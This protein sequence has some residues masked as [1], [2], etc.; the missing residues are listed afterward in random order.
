MTPFKR[1]DIRSSFDTAVLLNLLHTTRLSSQEAQQTES[2]P[3]IWSLIG[4]K[5]GDN[6]QMRALAQS[7]GDCHREIPLHYSVWELPVTLSA[8]PSLFGLSAR[9]RSH[10]KPPWPDLLLTAGRRNEAAALWIAKA[11]RGSTKLV[12][13]GRPWHHP[14]RFDLVLTT[15]QYMLAAAEKIFILDLPLNT[16]AFERNVSSRFDHLPRPH[17]ALLIGGHSGALTLHE[18]LARELLGHAS[19]LT[20]T[21]SGSL[22]VS[23]SART[24]ISTIRLLDNLEAPHHLWRWGEPNNPYQDYLASAD[25]LIVTSDSASMFADALATSKPVLIF[26]LSDS[27][28]WRHLQSYR[29][30]ALTHRLAMRLAPRRMRRDLARIHDRMVAAKHAEWLTGDVSEL[31]STTPFENRDLERAVAAVRRLVHTKPTS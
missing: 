15:P 9:T 1:G 23:T 25:A 19:R 14:D 5:A 18:P 8:R 30:K 2:G 10:I 31:P 6:A 17:L 12:Q 16:A 3:T 21:L 26:D 20:N 13:L 22:L 7:L 27:R 4:N 24:P 28:W 29:L 11:S